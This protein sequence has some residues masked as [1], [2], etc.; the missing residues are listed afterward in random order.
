MSL[1]MRRT[2][3]V[4]LLCASAPIRAQQNIAAIH[5][6]ALQGLDSVAEERARLAASMVCGNLKLPADAR[7]TYAL[8]DDY[9]ADGVMVSYIKS[10]IWAL[11][12][13]VC[14]YSEQLASNKA[15][16]FKNQGVC[17]VDFTAG[18]VQGTCE[19]VA[20]KVARPRQP[21]GKSSVLGHSCDLYHTD[22]ATWPGGANLP[23]RML[24]ESCEARLPSSMNVPITA[25]I[26]QHMRL[27]IKNST[28]ENGVSAVLL[29]WEAQKIEHGVMVPQSLLEPHKAPGLTWKGRA[30]GR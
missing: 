30:N 14:V 15:R 16:V 26:P 17:E 27:W 4:L 11:Q 29:T 24:S 2:Y 5:V 6:H 8:I 3:L 9:Y 1:K 23:V 28:V 18:T 13:P 20:S 25:G 7:S 10:Y 22:S 12:D 21:S 19:T